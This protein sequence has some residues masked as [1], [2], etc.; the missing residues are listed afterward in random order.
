[1]NAGLERVW[2]GPTHLLGKTLMLRPPRFDDFAEWRRIRLRDQALIE[3]FWHTSEL[4]WAQRHTEKHWVRECLEAGT[5]VRTG[6]QV[7]AVIEIDG[8][9]AGQIEL[10]SIDRQSRSGEMGIWIDAEQARHGFGGL[11]VSMMLDYG[12]DVLGLERLIAPISTE[13]KAAAH[14]ARQ[15][16]YVCEARLAAL[17]DVG[18]ARSD[19]NLWTVTSDR[20]PP[21]GFTETWINRV[22][23][24]SGAAATDVAQH[25]PA[26]AVQVARRHGRPSA[27]IILA[28]SAR[29]RV[30]QLRRIARRLIPAT[31]ISLPLTDHDG[32]A[33]RGRAG[34]RSA[35]DLVL[36]LDIHG[37]P[38]GECRLFDLDPFGRNAR[39]DIRID[40]AHADDGVRMAATR[41]LVDYAFTRLGMYRVATEIPST[42]TQFAA[43]LA[44]AGLHEEGTMRNFIGPTGHRADHTLWAITLRE[45][46]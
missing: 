43:V 3:P 34:F 33:L 30:G 7:S 8:R 11:A 38:A 32:V 2:L 1:M 9:F 24:R 5:S 37:V 42:D 18:G 17:F 40:S 6:R 21:K 41:A 12:L 36:T 16:G 35:T 4:S 25:A 20:I 28:V 14:G 27:T 22:T 39:M 10:G 31:A 23:A 15:V 45:C 29:Y 46:S 13:N 26:T 44:Q 19:H